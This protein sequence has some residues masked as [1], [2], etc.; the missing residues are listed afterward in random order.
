MDSL[1]LQGSTQSLNFRLRTVLPFANPGY[2]LSYIFTF[3]LLSESVDPEAEAVVEAEPRVLADDDVASAY[4]P[5]R[6]LPDHR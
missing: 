2:Y 3:V 4:Y 6:L 5:V 1:N